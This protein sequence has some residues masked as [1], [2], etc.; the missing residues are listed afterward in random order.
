MADEQTIPSKE[1]GKNNTMNI[2]IV[3]LLVVILAGG[4]FYFFSSKDNGNG[5]GPE[6]TPTVE[7]TSTP[8]PAPTSAPTPPPMDP[9]E[10][11]ELVNMIF[12]ATKPYLTEAELADMATVQTYINENPDVLDNPESA[13]AEVQTAYSNIESKISAVG[14]SMGVPRDFKVGDKHMVVGTITKVDES[15][16]ISPNT[17]LVTDTNDGADYYFV[18][19]DDIALEIDENMIDESVAIEIEISAVNTDG[20]YSYKVISNPILFEPTVTPTPTVTVTTTPT[21]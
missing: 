17:Y 9:E 15:D 19:T 3:V 11:L 8:S 16:E 20:S 4:A 18:F 13:P 5:E 12:E 6:P 1:E 10:R 2:I 14:V 21:N 7:P